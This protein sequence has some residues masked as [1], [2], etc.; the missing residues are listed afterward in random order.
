M[1]CAI[2]FTPPADDALTIAAARWLRRDP[3]TGARIAWPVE[4]LVETDHAFLTAAP[5]RIGFHGS[6][7]APFRIADEH[8]V[9]DVQAAL[10]KFCRRVP[11]LTVDAMRI[12]LIENFF[13]LV[14][15]TPN[16]ELHELAT[17]FVTVFDQ[18]RSPTTDLDLARG[19]IGRLNGR[20][21]ANLMAW[22]HPYVLDQFRFHMT[23]TGPIDE[24]EREY[25]AQMLH[26]HF[27]SLTD[28]PLCISQVALF[29]EPEP[30]APFLIDSIHRFTA[31]QQRKTA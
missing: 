5:R 26:R 3:Y 11:P 9:S 10:V 7:K 15:A 4:G 24:L 12:A 8:G 6:L 29:V 21:F 25:V 23:L 19:D 27:G 18:Y 1:R 30:N 2:C 13:A 16:L 17:D 14:P 28:E 22:G 20:Q 31:Q